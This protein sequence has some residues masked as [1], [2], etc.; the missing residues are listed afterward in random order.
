[1]IASKRELDILRF[2]QEQGSCSINFLADNLRVTTET[3]RRNLKPLIEKKVVVKFHGGVMLPH[4][5]P[6][7]PPFL[8]RMEVYAEEKKAAATE[9]AKHVVDGESLLI[10]TGT[11]TLYLAEALGNHQNLTVTTNSLDIA[12]QLA[13]KNN[14]KVM[15][16]S[17]EVRADD[18][19][20]FGNS[21]I[22]FIRQ[23]HANKALL[24]IGAISSDGELMNFHLCEAEFSRA[25]IRQAREVWVITDHS[26]FGRQGAVKVCDLQDVDV[27]VTDRNPPEEF[28]SHCRRANVRIIVH[29]PNLDL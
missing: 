8:K 1:M 26:K 9:A 10:D 5:P 24:S 17:G 18:V 14:N 19:A 2:I 13:S 12:R 3:I 25:L 21:A 15:M 28:V 7:E 6:H 29:T 23:V 16:V 20:V 4:V 22:E 11:T 27:I